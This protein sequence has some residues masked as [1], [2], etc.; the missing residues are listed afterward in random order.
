MKRILMSCLALFLCVATVQAEEP[1]SKLVGD[2]QVANVQEPGGVTRVPFITWGGDVATFHANGGLKTKPGSIFANQGLNLELTPGDDFVQQVRDYMT[3]KTPYLRGTMRMIGQASEVLNSN[4]QT[5]PVVVFQMTWSAG[6][7]IVGIASIKELGDLKGKR[8]AL[9]RGGPHLGLLDDALRA[10]GMTWKDIT[11]VWCKDLTATDESP[12]AK[13]RAGL[14]DA[15]CVITPDMIGLTGGLDSKGSGAEGTLKDARVV[16]STAQMSRSIADVYVCRRDYFNANKEKVQKFFAGYLKGC[17]EIIAEQKKYNDGKG[18]SAVYVNALK[19]AQ[20]IYGEEVIPTW[21]V[22]AHGLVLDCTYVRLPGN[23]SFFTDAGNLNGFEKKMAN[24]LD[25]ATSLGLASNRFGFEAPGFDYRQV[26]TL[27]G[28]E[29]VAP[30][31]STGRI[32]GEIEKFTEELDDNTILTFVIEFK[33]N[34]NTF[35][36]DTY[37]AEFK[38]V[39]ENASTFG[40]AVFAVRGHADPTA[41]LRSFLK[42]GMQKGII[43]RTGESEAN[44]GKGYTYYLRG[45]ELDLNQTDALVREI[46]Q[47]NF[48]GASENPNQ[49]MQAALNLSLTRSEAIKDAILEFAKAQGINLDPSQIQPQGVGIREPIV[50]KP[51]SMEEAQQNMRVEFRL[52]KVPAEALNASDFDF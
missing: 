32:Q 51:T 14:A 4:P 49:V 7:H 31:A 28:V 42:A 34:Q 18:S 19:L 1:F 5:K 11:V 15:A 22:D 29:Y 41:T 44:G 24:A 16:V 47:G 46:Q 39:I 23:V 6:D 35:S 21:E 43:T 8:V 2:V 30:V 26:A 52:I 25:L 36:V 9:Q 10:A 50:A 20:S 38:R 48:T 40:N 37:G 45:K 13:I 12:A 3:G 27:A 33:P 17:E